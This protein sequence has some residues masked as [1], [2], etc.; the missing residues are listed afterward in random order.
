M[1]C[2]HEWRIWNTREI[3]IGTCV[4]FTCRK[5]DNVKVKIFKENTNYITWMNMENK[6]EKDKTS[7]VKRFLREIQERKDQKFREKIDRI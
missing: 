1:K 3:N 5:C 6:K 4:S 2:K 7:F